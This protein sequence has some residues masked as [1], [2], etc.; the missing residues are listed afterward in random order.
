MYEENTRRDE[1]IGIQMYAFE[2]EI[3][4]SNIIQREIPYY[5]KTMN[6]FLCYIKFCSFITLFQNKINI[7]SSQSFY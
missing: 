5:L 3:K 2:F 1:R 7:L 4:I 6:I